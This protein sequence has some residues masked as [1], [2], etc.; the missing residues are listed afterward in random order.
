[1]ACSISSYPVINKIRVGN[2]SCVTW[3]VICCPLM[4]GRFTSSTATVGFRERISSSPSSPVAAWPTTLMSGS[5]DSA[6]TT[7]WRN[8]GWSSTTIRV[9]CFIKYVPS[10]LGCLSIYFNSLSSFPTINYHVLM[11]KSRGEPATSGIHSFQILCEKRVELGKRNQVFCM[12]LIQEAGKAGFIAHDGNH[13]RGHQTRQIDERVLIEE[14]QRSN[15]MGCNELT[16][17]DMAIRPV[18]DLHHLTLDQPNILAIRAPAQ[19]NEEQQKRYQGS[20]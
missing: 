14:T 13:L 1:M 9:I 15:I 18:G 5:S 2:L 8:R 16:R 6:S 12:A 19:E 10:D 7:P 17:G 20:A 3:W 11:P 4:P